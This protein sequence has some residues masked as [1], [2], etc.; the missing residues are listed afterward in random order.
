MTE[1]E[2]REM[3]ATLT[4]EEKRELLEWLRATFPKK[5]K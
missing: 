3:I 1:K 2:I 5:V 4:D